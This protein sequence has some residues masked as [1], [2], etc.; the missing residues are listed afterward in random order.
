MRTA[1]RVLKYIK[2]YRIYIILSLITAALSV[3]GTLY[4]PV[5]A[6]DAIDL[7]SQRNFGGIGIILA[8]AAVVAVLTAISTWVMNI[9]NNK[10]LHSCY[11]IFLFV[12]L[13]V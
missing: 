12:C 4:I 10:V 6:G 11:F 8:S 5:L 2:S 3:A 13:F 1:K 7:I 9:C